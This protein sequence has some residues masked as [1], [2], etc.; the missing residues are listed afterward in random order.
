MTT[1]HPKHPRDPNQLAKLIVDL[2][3]GVTTKL[4]DIADIVTMFEEWENN[5][6]GGSN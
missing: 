6:R 3:T 2:A 4:W 5:Q 1:K